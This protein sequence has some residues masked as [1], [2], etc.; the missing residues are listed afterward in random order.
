MY[1]ISIEMMFQEERIAD[2][3]R[4]LKQVIDK[5]LKLTFNMVC[6]YIEAAM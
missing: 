4:M 2:V 3:F 5:D 1:Q 6:V